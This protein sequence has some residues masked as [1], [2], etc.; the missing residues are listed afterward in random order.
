[1]GYKLILEIEEHFKKNYNRLLKRLTFR[2]GTQWAA[3]DVIQEAYTR[4]IKYHKSYSGAGLDPWIS[5]IV[6]N[7]LREYQ[8]A[9]KG[10]SHGPEEEE[11]AIDNSQF[12]GIMRD[13]YKMIEEKSPVHRE[14]LLYFF[15]YEYGPKDICAITNYSYSQCHQIIQRFRND[16]KGIYRE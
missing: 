5:T 2:A 1:M 9:E 4:A 6:N 16:L 14:V 12:R 7:A 10:Y 8:N 3:E 15:K 13:V 11:E